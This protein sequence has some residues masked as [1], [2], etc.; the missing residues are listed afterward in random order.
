MHP[1][2]T[3]EAVPGAR[4]FYPLNEPEIGTP[5]DSD[6]DSGGSLLFKPLTIRGTTFK[7]RIWVAPMCQ[8]SSDNGHATDWHLVHLGGFA[9]RGVGAVTVEAT[10]VVPE[11]RIAPEDAG[12]WTDT[13]IEPLRR[14]VSF[15]H[16]QGTKI[17]V[18]LAHAGRKAST[19]APWV[20]RRAGRGAPFTATEAE[21]G[22]PDGVYGPS[23]L[24]FDEERYPS[25]K[26]MTED[27]I[28]KVINAFV[29]SAKRAEKA[30]FDFIEIHAAHGY[31]LHSFVSPLSNTRNDTYGGQPLENRLRVIS[32][33]IQRLREVWSTKP[34]F[35]RISATDWAEGPEQD[36]DGKWL[37]WG[38]E[39]SK[40][41]ASRLQNF[42]VDLVDCSS[43]GNWAA[44][45]IPIKPGYQ[46]PFAAELKE[47]LPDLLVGTVG[48]IT[49]PEQAE[50]YLK[51]GKADVI[52]LARALMR[53]PHWALDAAQKLGIKVKPAN[54][55]E[56]AW[57]QITVPIPA[58]GR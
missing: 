52:F 41:L 25:P 32:S 46:V 42:G 8:Y 48:L 56:R 7:N 5:W 15:A 23:D 6:A 18:Q 33:L 55:Y 50:S 58:P 47:A 3:N 9:T 36:A 39:Q 40:I 20:Q 17:G 31:L 35:V 11:G 51:E 53:N 37:Q 27:D 1:D 26:Q 14:V 30:G 34:L 44:Q 29:E 21:N 13:Q 43:G 45:A 2:L 12:L 54:Q 38:I 19:H 22:W 4:E 28:N 24:S 10:S 16:A 49:E 57:G